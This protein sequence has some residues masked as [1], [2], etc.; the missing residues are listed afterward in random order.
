SRA[1]LAT[2]G[3]R[4]GTDVPVFVQGQ[5]AWAEGIGEILTPIE[6][7]EAW[8][9]VVVP[10]VHVSTAQVFADP[11]LTRYSP[12]LTIRDF[13]AGRGLQN[14]LE[15]LV[16]SRYPEVDRAMR[17]LGEFGTPRMSGSGG[18]AFLKVTGMDHGRK[19]LERIPKPFTGFV[20]RGMNR[21]PLYMVR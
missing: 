8:Y 1:E 3:L 11:E 20:A 16:R 17:L 15:P 19:I 2:L 12:P 21:H 18:C 9:L 14:D 6:P 4:L 10:P 13:Q 5:A 7:E